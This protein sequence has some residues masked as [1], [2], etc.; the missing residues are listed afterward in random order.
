MALCDVTADVL[1]IA[2]RGSK[3]QASGQHSRL[4]FI[5]AGGGI[6][7][8]LFFITNQNDV[9]SYLQHRHE[10]ARRVADVLAVHV[11]D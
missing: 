11:C 7:H 6:I 3:T 4:G 5:A 2:N 8:E 10:L 1:E 9:K